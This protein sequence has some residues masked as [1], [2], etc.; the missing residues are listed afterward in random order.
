MKPIHKVSVTDQTVEKLKELIQTEGYQ[1]GDRLPTQA[2]I[3]LILNIGRSAVRE[4]IRV[5]EAEGVVEVL[6]GK[7]VFI[8]NPVGNEKQ[9][10]EDWYEQN[11]TRIT[12]FVNVRGAM[13]PL[14]IKLAMER[15]TPA[16]MEKIHEKL[17][18]FEQAV[19]SGDP[20]VMETTDYEFHKAILETSRNQFI[21]N[22]MDNINWLQRELRCESFKSHREGLNAQEGHRKMYD[23]M[24]TN[25]VEAA[26]E[27]MR[28]HVANSRI[29]YLKMLKN[30][31][32]ESMKKTL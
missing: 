27:E 14:A 26:V 18:A 21:L 31:Q 2:E 32:P 24:V 7:G 20:S 9:N 15:A 25:Q 8:I 1:I 11:K 19:E 30:L 22:I 10:A 16:D 5:L 23:A 4:A 17:L 6:C 3:G 28:V 12:D 29:N 13:E